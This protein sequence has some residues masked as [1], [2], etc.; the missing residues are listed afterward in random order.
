VAEEGREPERPAQ[1]A[2]QQNQ[3]SAIKT[4]NWSSGDRVFDG[5][6]AGYLSAG[7]GSRDLL[8]GFQARRVAPR[9]RDERLRKADQL[10]GELVGVRGEERCQR[11]LDGSAVHC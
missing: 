11:L 4:W 5:P 7:I 1:P 2:C 3:W 10:R 9:L 8:L 6:S